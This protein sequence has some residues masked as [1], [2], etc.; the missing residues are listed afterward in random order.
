MHFLGGAFGILG[1]LALVGAWVAGE[2]GAVLGFS[3]QHLYFD[4]V[5]LT[6]IGI[7]ALVCTLVYLK[8]ERK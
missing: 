7:S 5:V 6:L 3:Q 1:G 2:N 4:A 8:Q